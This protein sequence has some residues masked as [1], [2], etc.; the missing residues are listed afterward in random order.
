MC[1]ISKFRNFYLKKRKKYCLKKYYK[2]L[3]LVKVGED[4]Y[5]FVK[6]IDSYIQNKSHYSA[7]CKKYKDKS[8]LFSEKLNIVIP[9]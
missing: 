1:I 9:H 7:L 3:F 5:G 6:D 2:Y 8:L 4:F